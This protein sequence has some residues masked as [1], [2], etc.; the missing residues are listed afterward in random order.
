MVPMR[1][2]GNDT[3]DG[4]AE[5]ERQVPI[6]TGGRFS[7]GVDRRA[8]FYFA[9]PL[10]DSA[11][12]DLQAGRGGEKSWRRR[13][14]HHQFPKIILGV[15]FADRIECQTA[16]STRRRLTPDHH[17]LSAMALGGR[18]D[19]A[20]SRPQKNEQFGFVLRIRATRPRSAQQH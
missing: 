6:T 20:T 13:D 17:Q 16:K 3:K 10:S 5:M 8:E 2:H 9:G 18:R 4:C 11:R 19:A 7:Y 15:K 14:R 12:Y 1:T